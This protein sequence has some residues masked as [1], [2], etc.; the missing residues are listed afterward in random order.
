M[1]R[2]SQIEQ[3][4]KVKLIRENWDGFLNYSIAFPDGKITCA[5]LLTL[6]EVEE[7][8]KTELQRKDHKPK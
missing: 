8:I 1:S 7:F 4:Y 5:W 2:T 6:D 3:T